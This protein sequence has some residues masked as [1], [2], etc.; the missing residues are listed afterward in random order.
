[1]INLISLVS[2]VVLFEMNHRSRDVLWFGKLWIKHADINVCLI[3]K[4]K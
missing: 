3:Y 2:F 1:M 4:F